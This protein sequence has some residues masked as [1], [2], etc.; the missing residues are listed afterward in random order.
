MTQHMT[1]PAMA[2]T[3]Q[4]VNQTKNVVLNIVLW[5]IQVLL[6]GMFLMTG[7]AKLTGAPAMV[8]L[9][10]TIGVGQWFR[11][12]TGAIELGSGILVLIPGMAA[13]AA[14]LLGCTMIGAILTHLTILHSSPQ[15][16][17]MLLVGA[18]VILWGRSGQLTR[19]L[20]K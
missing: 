20:R 16:P 12:V 19:L 3:P 4:A 2:R 1:Q 17:V 8:G 18:A 7:W 15:M 6:A 5:V 14:V 11:Y 9:Y 10:D 13:F